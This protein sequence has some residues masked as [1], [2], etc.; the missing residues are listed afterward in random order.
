MHG[1][2][3]LPKEVTF[4]TFASSAVTWRS[5]VTISGLTSTSIAS[6]ATKAS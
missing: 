4:V 6:S 1:R 5:P 3:P 2:M